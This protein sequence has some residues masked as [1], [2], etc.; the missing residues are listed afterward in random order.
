MKTAILDNN[1]VKMIDLEIPRV[2]GNEIL[3]KMKT[4]GICGS[5]LE[6]VFGK[7]GMKSSKIGHEPAGIIQKVGKDVK[8]YKENDRVFVHHH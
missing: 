7:Y 8:E 1:T 5:D 3:V 6:K 2:G 4:C